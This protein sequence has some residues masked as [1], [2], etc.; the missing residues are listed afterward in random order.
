MTVEYRELSSTQLG[1]IVPEHS[2][3]DPALGRGADLQAVYG[4][5]AGTACAS[6]GGRFQQAELSATATTGDMTALVTFASS[7]PAVASVDGY[8]VQGWADGT[9]EVGFS[10]PAAGRSG[11]TIQKAPTP[12]PSPDPTPG[13]TR[14]PSPAPYQLLAPAP[15][16]QPTR[17]PVPTAL[18]TPEPTPPPTTLPPHVPTRNCMPLPT[19]QPTHVPIP[20]P[21]SLPIPQ[22]IVQPYCRPTPKPG[23]APTPR[24]SPQPTHVPSPA[25]T[26]QPMSTYAGAPDIVQVA[27]PARREK[28]V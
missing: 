3:G 13:P 17:V 18:P 10:L 16:P 21:L 23:L 20:V 6:Y 28:N 11:I 14:A 25:P 4:A 8:V 22:P 15:A 9:A 12:L 24:P 19:P 5:Y 26:P 27:A 2:A 7:T 1:L